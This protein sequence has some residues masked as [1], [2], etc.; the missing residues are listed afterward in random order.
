MMKSLNWGTV[1]NH[2]VVEFEDTV[3]ALYN[4]LSMTIPISSH[5]IMVI[6]SQQFG[7]V[8]YKGYPYNW[9][10][11]Q[12]DL[13]N[14]WLDNKPYGLQLALYR[15]LFK[16]ITLRVQPNLDASM[17]G[18]FR[19]HR[20]PPTEFWWKDLC[21]HSSLPEFVFTG[22]TPASHRIVQKCGDCGMSISMPKSKKVNFVD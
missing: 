21:S 12:F 2:R 18:K 8:L 9:T 19:D 22:K 6:L 14:V 1:G 11:K 5:P 17:W 7:V 15:E 13:F 4:P 3:H 16:T 20:H 10:S